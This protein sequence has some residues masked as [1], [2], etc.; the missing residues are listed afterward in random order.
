MYKN[1]WRDRI[2]EWF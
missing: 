2:S 1:W